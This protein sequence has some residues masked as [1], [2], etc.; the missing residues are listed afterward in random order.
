MIRQMR[1][2]FTVV[3]S[4]ENEGARQTRSSFLPQQI[5]EEPEAG[6]KTTCR[7]RQVVMPRLDDLENIFI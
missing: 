1:I 6:G 7:C 2:R 4:I 3:R 5:L